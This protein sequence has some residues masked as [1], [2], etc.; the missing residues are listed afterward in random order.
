VQCDLG[1]KTPDEMNTVGEKSLCHSNETS[2]YL[3]P[4][5]GYEQFFKGLKANSDDVM[6]S[7][8]IGPSNPLEVELR[9]PPGGG[10]AIPAVASACAYTGGVGEESADPAVRLTQLTSRFA[11]HTIGTICQSDLSGALAQLGQ[12]MRL[13][14]GDACISRS[15]AQPPDCKVRE[16][17]GSSSTLLPACNNGAS[18]T[19][20]PC[21]ELVSDLVACGADALKVVV[22][23][24]MAPAPETVVVV[25]CRL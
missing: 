17:T 24:S 9:T 7:A 16:E 23:R 6:V 5:S 15:I 22:Q 21:Y 8:I 25:A 11:R 10:T 4:I 14:I 2:A 19:N 18:S 1:G 3:T 20:K 13:F 12:E